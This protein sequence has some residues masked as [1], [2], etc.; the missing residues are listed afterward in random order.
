M[1]T[2]I[3]AALVF[4]PALAVVV[5]FLPRAVLGIVMGALCAIGVFEFLNCTKPGIPKRIPAVTAF[6]SA[7]IPLGEALGYG[8]IVSDAAFFLM[9]VYLYAELM[10][11]FK[12]DTTLGWDMVA[13]GMMGGFVFP[14]CLT[15]I[16]RLDS[17][18]NAYV[19]LVFLVA[20][21]SDTCAYFAGVFLGKHKLVPRLSPKKTI[22]GSI[23]GFVG[24]VAVMLIYGAVLKHL[25]YQVQFSILAIYGFLGSLV[26][27]FG[28]LSFSAVKR[29]GGVKDYGNLIPGHG[30]VYDRFDGMAFV[31]IAMELLLRWVPAIIV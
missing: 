12:D 29:I 6:F 18:G 30:G 21:A 16:V 28:D 24:T 11:S 17:M 25:G 3:L 26:C 15:S 13:A 9:L 22:E 14:W 20:F 5:F 7:L 23:G 19:A 10:Y 31:A 2:R 8:G 4:V 27:Q 1:K